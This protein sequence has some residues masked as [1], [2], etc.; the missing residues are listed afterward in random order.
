[1]V[2]LWL[3]PEPAATLALDG[4]LPPDQLH[5]TLAI[6]EADAASLSDVQQA[7]FLTTVD[8]L[9]AWTA[10]LSGDVAGMGRFY[11]S[12]S[13]DGQDVLFA[14]PNVE[15]L[16]KL[17]HRLCE[18]L[19]Y[20]QLPHKDDFEFFPHISLAYVASG[21]ES[22]VA[23]V[24][25]TPLSF[26]ALTVVM[27]D[28][29]T[30]VPLRGW[31]DGAMSYADAG[32][33]GEG[34]RLFT[35][36]QTYIEPPEWLPLMPAPGNYVHRDYG[37]VDLPADRIERLVASINNGVYQK[38]IPIDVSH[39]KDDLDLNGGLGW[40]GTARINADGSADVRVEWTPRGTEAL[41]A[42]RFRYV[43]P[44]FA[45]SWKDEDG[46]DHDDVVLGL[47][48]CTNPFFKDLAIDRALVASERG[49]SVSTLSLVHQF[50]EPV[51]FVAKDQ[52]HRAPEETL[53][54]DE[55]PAV[56]PTAQQFTELSQSFSDLKTSFGELQQK[57]TE[58][59]TARE[60][61]KTAREAAEAK[62]TEA[63]ARI[64]AMEDA[65]RRKEFTDEVLGKSDASGIRWFGNA[66]NH[67]KILESFTDDALRQTY[68]DEQRENAKRMTAAAIKPEIGSDAPGETDIQSQYNAEVTRVMT[69]S[70]VSKAQ[71]TRTVLRENR[72]LAAAVAAGKVK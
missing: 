40:F 58:S 71:A 16:G 41:L 21:A 30:T 50:G 26:T 42:D 15:G 36:L 18:N 46:V 68:I 8:D 5:I 47:A 49:A 29:M 1:M 54:A 61:E 2:G 32:I 28:R 11:A 4:Q 14:I 35:E 45:L 52:A 33:I 44:E 70:K 56:A 24:A 25:T 6:L 19:G 60:T 31:S 23:A 72:E 64:Q 57:F 59:E 38:S 12:D 62:A 20:A 48:L 53:M 34:H 69:E 17:R 63:D 37:T 67:I 13:S 55:K 65:K 27:G 22:P 3:A 10:P 43:S 66:D 7:R 9:A 39:D 51:R